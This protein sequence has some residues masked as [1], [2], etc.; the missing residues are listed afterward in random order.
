VIVTLIV[1]CEIAFWAVLAAGLSLRYFLRLPRA[2]AVVLACVPLVDV[3][4]L[5]A[6]VHDLRHVGAADARH[7]LAA[8]YIGFSVGYGRYMVRWADGHFAHRFASGPKPAK[9]PKYG[10]AR[11][12]HEWRMCAR[13]ALAAAIAAALLQGAIWIVGHPDRTAAL[14]QWQLSMAW[15]TGV[16]A[17]IAASYTLWP[18]REPVRR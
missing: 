2:G 6:T 7:G 13:T 8:V 15:V 11:A 14:R 9:P 3:V 4:L 1:G 10:A 17:V 16:N 18:K 12:A 5:V